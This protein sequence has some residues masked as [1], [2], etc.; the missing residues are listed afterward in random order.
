MKK[1]FS[2]LPLICLVAV[3]C[4]MLT[5]CDLFGGKNG[6]FSVSVKDVGSSYVDLEFTGPEAIEVAYIL[7]TKEQLMNNPSVIFKSGVEM[8]V[9][10]GDV[11]RITSGIDADK[12]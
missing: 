7:E 6:K 2:T 1:F 11:V 12:Q 8:T 3:L 5:G 4:G 10:G 9:S